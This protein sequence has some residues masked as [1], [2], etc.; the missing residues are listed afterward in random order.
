MNIAFWSMTSGRSATSGNMLAVSV[1]SSLAYDFKENIVQLDQHSRAV[2]DVFGERR[3]TN[4]LMEEYSYYSKKGL[5]CLIDKSQLDDLKLKDL[6]ENIVSVKDTCINYVPVSRRT[7][8]GVNNRDIINFSKKMIEILNQTEALNFIDCI[9]GD[10]P[11]SKSVLKAADVIVVNLSQGM[12]VSKLNLDKDILKK[13]VFL[14]GK[15]DENSRENVSDIRKKYGIDREDIA[16]IPY[17]I[18]FNDAI[19]EGKLVSYISKNMNSKVNDD[20]LY[21]INQLFLATNMI[22]RKAGY[23]AQRI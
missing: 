1:M 8:V 13:A 2:D 7:T 21:F 10:V 22:L 16:V 6:G 3:Q 4:L 12:T 19:H 15:Y 20:D 17:N 5:D 11:M 23:D 14:V 18:H 9:N